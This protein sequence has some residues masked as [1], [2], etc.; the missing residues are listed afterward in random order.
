MRGRKPKSSQVKEAEGNPGKRAIVPSPEF[1]SGVEPPDVLSG[2]AIAITEWDRVTA[3]LRAARILQSNDRMML[4]AYCVLYSRWCQAESQLQNE[5]LIIWQDEKL[6]RPNPLIKISQDA[7][8]EARAIADL[9]GFSPASRSRVQAP[10]QSEE[11]D[12]L[13]EFLQ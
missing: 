9:F 6:P 3:E 7:L 8:K 11:T 2:D 4:A 5:E 10:V 1:S 12:E 13:A